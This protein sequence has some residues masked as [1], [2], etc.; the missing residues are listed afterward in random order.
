MP[1]SNTTKLRFIPWALGL[2]WLAGLGPARSVPAADWPGFRGPNGSAVSDEKGLPVKW[3]ATEGLRWKAALPGRG[4]SNPVIAGGRVYVTCCSGYRE[5]RLHVLC[6]DEATGDKLWE[7][8]FAATGSTTCNPTTCMAAPTPVTDGQHLFALFATGDLAAFDADGTL[9]WYRSLVGDY[10]N[11]SNQVGMAAS[12]T[13]SGDTLLVP[14]ENVGESFVAGLDKQTG[15]NRWKVPR[16]KTINWV[17]PIVASSGDRPAALFVA[18]K[19]I[20]ALDPRTGKARWSL[21]TEGSSGIPSPVAGEGLIFVP[22]KQFF[23]LKPGNGDTTPEVVWQTGKV[24]FGYASPVYHQMRLYVIPPNNVTCLDAQNGKELWKQRVEGSYWATPV[25]ADGK[26][27]AVNEKGKTTVLQLGDEPKV[28]AVNVLDDTILATPA[29]SG[30]AIYLRS[31][32]MLY[33]IGEKKG[34]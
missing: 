5:R 7:R 22:G 16:E 19:D 18:G 32:K 20:T 23:A 15:K 2:V 25:L 26:L 21:A 3:S 33:C 4:L 8:Q 9:L 30:G 10:P 12:P 17:S 34:K 29:I 31:D 27:Y 14:L 11:I 1:E 13:L 28:L 24:N 6:F